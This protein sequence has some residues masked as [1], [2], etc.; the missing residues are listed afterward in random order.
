MMMHKLSLLF[1]APEI[2]C[3]LPFDVCVLMIPYFEIRVWLLTC[4]DRVFGLKKL[5]GGIMP[6]Q[7]LNGADTSQK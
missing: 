4:F 5:G 1:C 6:N 3:L 7:L 2:E